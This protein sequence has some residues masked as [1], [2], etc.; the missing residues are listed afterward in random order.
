[1]IRASTWRS[2]VMMPD[3][4]PVKLIASPPSS[5]IAIDSSAIEMRSPAV[6][7]MSSSRRSGLGDT[8]LA[9]REQIVGRVAH[10]R[11]D[12]DD[13]VPVALRAHHALGDLLDARRRRRRWSRRISGRRWT[14]G[15]TDCRSTSQGHAFV[16]S[17]RAVR[18]C[19]VHFAIQRRRSR[20]P[21]R[22]R[23][24]RSS[25]CTGHAVARRGERLAGEHVVEPPADV[26]LAHV[27][28]RRPPRE[29]AVVVGIER[30]ADVD[31][32]AAEDPLDQRALL[33]QLADRARLALLRMHVALGARDVH[34][35]AAATS[36]AAARL[37][38]RGDTR[39]S[40][41]GTPSSPGSPCRRSAR[42]PTRRSVAGRV[43]TST[44]TMRFS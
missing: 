1:M 13:V 14:C 30:A 19:F 8:C 29:Q 39:P 37:V 9:R 10:R 2:L 4:L 3:W 44:V 42:R 32:A 23:W 34:V 33:R 17:F 12:D 40:P 22:D 24:C 41:R 25:F 21:A 26:A 5:R 43:A 15:A 28:P 35:A 20:P 38:R 31:Q 6:S 18:I 27:A 11:D 36:S 16:T 7:S